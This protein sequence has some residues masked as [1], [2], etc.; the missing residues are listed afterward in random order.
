M[1]G[2]TIAFAIDNDGAEAVGADLVRR[3]QD[4]PAVVPRNADG[5]V[6]SSIDVQV[7][8]GAVA[9]RLVVFIGG[10]KASGNHS[11]FLTWQ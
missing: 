7:N 3:S 9:A 5:F 6:D 8:E 4:F 1:E 11:F 2:D 10:S